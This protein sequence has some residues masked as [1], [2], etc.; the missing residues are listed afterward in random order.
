MSSQAP[1]VVMG[2]APATFEQFGSGEVGT[3]ADFMTWYQALQRM[4]WR[5][6][7]GG[8]LEVLLGVL[9]RGATSQTRTPDSELLERQPVAEHGSTDAR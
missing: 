7:C 8:E 2:C 4:W 5:I 6:S 1:A 3:P 9:G